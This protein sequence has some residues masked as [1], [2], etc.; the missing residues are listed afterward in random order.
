VEARQTW[1]NSGRSAWRCDNEEEGR[2][3]DRRNHDERGRWLMKA[4]AGSSGQAI[5]QKIRR[6]REGG[7]REG[8]KDDKEQKGTTSRN[9]QG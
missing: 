1:W 5:V 9:C 2:F 6:G 4:V 3:Q 8:V 7:V